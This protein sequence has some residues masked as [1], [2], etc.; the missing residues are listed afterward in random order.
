MLYVRILM[1]FNRS[2]VVLVHFFVKNVVVVHTSR[3]RQ[4]GFSS[5]VSNFECVVVSDCKYSPPFATAS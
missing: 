1:S 4:I 2:S 5:S 3:T